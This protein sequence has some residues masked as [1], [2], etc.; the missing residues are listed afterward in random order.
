M[1]NDL[2]PEERL[3]RL[4]RGKTKRPK[5]TSH[6]ETQAKIG[7]PRSSGLAMIL[8]K[9]YRLSRIFT[10][11]RIRIILAIVIILSAGYLIFE[12]V[13]PQPSLELE[14]LTSANRDVKMDKAPIETSDLKPY[15]HYSQQIDTRDI[16]N[17]PFLS[18][19]VIDA[20]SGSSLGNE[21]SNL[22]IV[23]IVLDELP[24]VII[25]DNKDK[26]TYFLNKGDYIGEIKIE[27]ILEGKVIVSYAGEEFE[28]AP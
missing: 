18:G 20:S 14:K 11:N 3:L 19:R 17:A 8:N 4:I 23:G 6:S 21:F 15:S 27:D 24:Q 9:F 22:S 16:F 25:E 1:V 28:M 7:A 26:K 13:I 2:T 5:M 10:F 12:S